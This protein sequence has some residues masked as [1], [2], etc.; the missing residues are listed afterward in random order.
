MCFDPDVGY[1]DTPVLWRPELRAGDRLVGPAVVEEFGSTVPVHP[2]VEM[3]V[4]PWG[5]LVL[6]PPL[7]AR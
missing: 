7:E 1:V 6:T 2:G 3:R 5:N 4:D